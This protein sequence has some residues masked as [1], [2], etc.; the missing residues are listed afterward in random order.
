MKKTLVTYDTTDNNTNIEYILIKE[1]K[2]ATN[3]TDEYYTLDLS[4]E[5]LSFGYHNYHNDNYTRNI[6]SSL[7]VIDFL[8]TCQLS[9]L[10]QRPHNEDELITSDDFHS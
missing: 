10:T 2:N 4:Y 9:Q 1:V 3:S 6:N 5:H 7:N 8:L